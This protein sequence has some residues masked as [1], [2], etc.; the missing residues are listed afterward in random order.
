MSRLD[1]FTLN[2]LCNS[3]VIDIDQD[4]RGKQAGIVRHSVSEF[5]LS[6]TLE[7]GALA[8]GLF[9]LAEAKVKLTV[10]WEELGLKGQYRIRDVWRQ[11]EIGVRA[12]EF[13]TEVA[14]HGVALIHLARAD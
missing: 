4:A 2:V 13:S 12:D 10:K 6:K 7:G 14:P 3:E 8:V 1:A 11:K 9:N 5:V